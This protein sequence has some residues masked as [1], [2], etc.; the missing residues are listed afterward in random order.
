LV[1]KK[2]VRGKQVRH[3]AEVLVRT[4]S[5]HMFEHADG[6]DLVIAAAKIPVVALK[7][8]RTPVQAGDGVGVTGRGSGC[9]P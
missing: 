3:L 6:G 9:N 1:E 4:A 7:D 2:S 5:A 8:T